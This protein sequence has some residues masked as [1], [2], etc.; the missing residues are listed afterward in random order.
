MQTS[1]HV[2]VDAGIWLPSACMLAHARPLQ[3][4]AHRLE[5]LWV[6]FQGLNGTR[7]QNLPRCIVW[8]KE[9]EGRAVQQ[10]GQLIAAC[11]ALPAAHKPAK[12]R[13]GAIVVDQL[14]DVF[15]A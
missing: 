15:A 6:L 8:R 5:S 7:W 10:A 4:A 9:R 3:L 1:L 11:G 2:N 13:E 12:L 14:R